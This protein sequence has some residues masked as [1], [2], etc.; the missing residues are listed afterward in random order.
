LQTLELLQLAFFLFLF[1]EL[2]EFLLF[3]ELLQSGCEDMGL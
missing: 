1:S 2:I 3:F